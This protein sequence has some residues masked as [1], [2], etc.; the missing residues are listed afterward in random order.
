MGIRKSWQK[1]GS[2]GS[3]QRQVMKGDGTVA[4]ETGNTQVS[5]LVRW[6]GDREKPG[7]RMIPRGDATG[8]VG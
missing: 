3:G 6:N 8:S 4:L 5:G 2:A 1:G 7:G